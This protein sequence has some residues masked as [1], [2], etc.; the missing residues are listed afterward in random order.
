[1]YPAVR[2]PVSVIILHFKSVQQ[3]MAVRKFIVHLLVFFY[4]PP[5]CI[6]FYKSH[7][8][9]FCCLIC[10]N[11]S[12]RILL[13]IFNFF[14]C[15]LYVGLKQ[16]LYF[17][18]FDVECFFKIPLTCEQ[19]LSLKHYVCF[20]F[21]SFL[22]VGHCPYSHWPSISQSSVSLLLAEEETLQCD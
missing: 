4:S 16:Y 19:E 22:P 14:Q 8:N 17:S 13:S 21:Y 20:S 3:K 12:L 1:M 9:F 10:F 7:F 5:I 18:L 2:N 15:F 11:L 6:L